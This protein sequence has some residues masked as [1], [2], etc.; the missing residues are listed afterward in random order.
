MQLETLM[1]RTALVAKERSLAYEKFV[2]RR[3]APAAA[4]QDLDVR[5]Q[6][7]RLYLRAKVE[8]VH[9]GRPDWPRNDPIYRWLTDHTTRDCSKHMLAAVLGAAE[10]A[11]SEE[12]RLR[13]K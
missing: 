13:S 12:R 2:M 5:L 11:T 6:F 8:H 4:L 7:E 9:P 3:D 1:E 10:R